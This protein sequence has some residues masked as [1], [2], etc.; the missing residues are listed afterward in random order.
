METAHGEGTS[1][2]GVAVTRKMEETM[3]DVGE[4]FLA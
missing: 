3:N 4:E 1:A 2:G